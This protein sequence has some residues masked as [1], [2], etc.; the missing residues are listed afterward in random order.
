MQSAIVSTVVDIVNDLFG[1]QETHVDLQETRK[2][3]KGDLTLVVFP[4]LR[5]SKK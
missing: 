3:F 5:A 2:E 4:Y 1:I